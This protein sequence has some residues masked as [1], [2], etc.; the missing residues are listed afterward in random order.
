MY[1]IKNLVNNKCY[2]GQTIN[3][4]TTRWNVHL[5]LARRNKKS[6]F[7]LHNA[8]RKYGE[9]NFNVEILAETDNIEQLNLLEDQYIVENNTMFPNG[10]NLKRGGFNKTYSE[11]SKQKMSLTAMGNTYGLGIKRNPEVGKKISKANSGENNPNFGKP[12]HNR[13]VA[14]SEEQKLKCSLAKLGKPSN[15]KG[16]KASLKTLEN[17]SRARK[18]IPWTEARRQAQNKLR[19]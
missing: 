8:I 9:E 19:N 4:I 7:A 16:K 15:N 2:I 10:Y 1:L 18:G 3:P 11:E 6:G 13:G 5:S 12:A 14:M 17:M